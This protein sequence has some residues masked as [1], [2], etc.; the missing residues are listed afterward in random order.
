MKPRIFQGLISAAVE[1]PIL[2]GMV[3]VLQGAVK[4]ARNKMTSLISRQSV[5]STG[6]KLR[7][8]TTSLRSVAHE[9]LSCWMRVG[10]GI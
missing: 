8:P 5:G 7:R 3:E 6:R 10:F 4:P 1:V 9:G 2:R